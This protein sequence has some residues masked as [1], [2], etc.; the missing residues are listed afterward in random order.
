MKK[1]KTFKYKTNGANTTTENGGGSIITKLTKRYSSVKFLRNSPGRQGSPQPVSTG[2]Y[3]MNGHDSGD[4][5]REIGAPIL[6]SKTRLDSDTTDCCIKSSDST[7]ATERAQSPPHYDVPIAAS[8]K[9]VPNVNKYHTPKLNIEEKI[10]PLKDSPINNEQ[11]D[12]PMKPRSTILQKHRSKSATNL[13]KSEIKVF[14]HKAP[15]L[16]LEHNNNCID[17]LYTEDD[18]ICYDIPQPRKLQFGADVISK[19]TAAE[20]YDAISHKSQ[21]NLSPSSKHLLVTST[22][23]VSTA[24]SSGNLSTIYNSKNSLT[25]DASQKRRSRDSLGDSNCYSYVDDDFDLKSASFQSLDARNLVLSIDELNEITRQINESD[26]FTNEIDLEYCEHRDKLKPDQRR[27]TLLRNKNSRA[28][29]FENKK[30]KFSN[31]W[32]GLKNWIG[33]ERGKLKEVINKHAALQRVGGTNGS[34]TNIIKNQDFFDNV[35]AAGQENNRKSVIID[36]T[37]HASSSSVLSSMYSNQQQQNKS[38]SDKNNDEDFNRC[39]QQLMNDDDDIINN[40][41]CEKKICA[42]DEELRSQSRALSSE[43]RDI[44]HGIPGF[45]QTLVRKGSKAPSV[46]KE[47]EIL[48]VIFLFFFSVNIICERKEL[49]H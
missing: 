16:E 44:P 31:A 30:E 15:S 22:N 29:N 13:H 20:T 27:I 14:L 47:P 34:K 3:D 25:K 4:L 28:I 12:V 45:I 42:S 24:S 46:T 7:N 21:T 43:E 11:Y 8:P 6:I 26:E 36:D 32:S 9:I 38:A 41:N 48:E 37:S 49:S 23:N 19:T 2:S 18:N 10:A 39:N 33:E 1:I 17:V 35:K 40:A 5:K